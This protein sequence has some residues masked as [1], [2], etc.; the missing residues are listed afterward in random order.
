MADKPL[1]NPVLSLQKE[2]VP[3]PAQGGGP[4]AKDVVQNRLGVQRRALS[5][6]IEKIY[7]ARSDYPTQGNRLHLAVRMFDDSYAPSWTPRTLF[8]QRFGCKLVAPIADGYL[9]E[10]S[11]SKLPQLAQFIRDAS[12]VEAMVAISRV[13]EIVPFDGQELLRHRSLDSVWEAASEV[14][15]GK[16][17]VLW[18]APYY[19]DASRA[20]VIAVLE[21]FER[22]HVLVPTYPGVSL[23]PPG[24]PSGEALP[25]VRADQTGLARAMR[26]YRN[27]GAARSVVTIPTKHALAT[28][29]S[30]GTSFRIDP[31]RRIEV[32][33]PGAGAEPVPP[34]PNL[35]AHPVVA[36]IDG[37]LTAQSYL[38][39]EAWRAPA[40][41]PDRVADHPHGNRVTSLVVHAHAW[42]NQ[43]DLP[44]LTCRVA[45]VQAIP[46]KGGNYAPNTEQLVEYLRRVALNYPEARVWNMSFNQVEPEDDNDVVS[47]L[48]HEIAALAREANIL[49]VISVG[50][51][52]L[53]NADRLCAPADCE[54]ALTV[55]GRSFDRSGKPA[56]VCPVSLKGPGPDG[57]LKPDLSWYSNLRMLGG[58]PQ[59]GSSYAVPLVSSLAAH[60]YANLKDPSP[61]LVRA[62]L[63]NSTERETHDPSL[64]W[65]TPW[66]GHFPWACPPGT[67]ALAW[68]SKLR[69]GFRYYWNDIPI[70]PEMIRAG[71]L[72]GKARLTAIL[73]P[74]VS[75]LAS[76]NYFS[77]RLQVAL[78]Y[79]KNDGQ[80][81]NLLGSMKEDKE[82]EMD[83]RAD[84]AKWQ[85]IRHHTR[86]FSK[87][88]GI[89]FQ[90]ST[91]RLHAR[92]FA[93]D[94]FQ[95]DIAN[96]HEL[97]EQEVAFVLSFS[98]GS[99]SSSIYN[100]VAQRLGNFVESAVIEQSIDVEHR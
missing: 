2:P 98:D 7:G 40:L 14:E 32:T 43:L 55:G 73:K 99:Q 33:A 77:T 27:E 41:V 70:P 87:R 92:I 17:F 63:I 80:F 3:E 25:V 54:A 47:Y 81:G 60:T 59:Q 88:G 1:L 31:V 91:M 42:N 75:E 76:A 13:E 15:G 58:T 96:H 22:Q 11:L 74:I 36:V 9:A 78:Q 19:E 84:L 100:S 90:G 93:R 86:D 46:R 85:P 67:V 51:K 8:D 18:L 57:M 6:R 21:E 89:Q 28:I 65:G 35:N 95:F 12:S 49:P 97:G 23:L 4:S 68:R 5:T 50:N 53:S 64:G 71:K 30:S 37:G 69:P 39:L 38:G 83:A 10:A 34:I 61:D 44:A 29:V 79:T 48:G 82:R 45:T 24:R 72:V 52:S 62:L 26:H 16:A 56:G 94:L 20:A 66:H